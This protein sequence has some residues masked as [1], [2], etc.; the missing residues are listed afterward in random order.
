MSAAGAPGFYQKAGTIGGASHLLFRARFDKYDGPDQWGN[1]GNFGIGMDLNGDGALDLILMMS[2]SSGNV[3]NRSRTL[4]WGDPGTGANTGPSTTSWAFPTQTATALVV[5]T[6]YDAVQATDSTVNGTSDL[7]LSF[8]V[9]FANLQAAV[10]AYTP[11]TTFTMTY[12]T[13]ITYIAFTS[14]QANSLNQDL[15]GT[16]GNTNSSLTWAQLG[17]ITGPADAYGVVP[18]PA[19][20]VQMAALFAAGTLVAW[21]R[22]RC[23][24]G[25]VGR[26]GP[27]A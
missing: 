21:R 19:T 24:S 9:S 12:D 25:V 10:R 13:R 7:L 5:N 17:A 22:R 27:A 26:T 20:Y 2:E 15:F 3:N 23:L 8:A 18:E 1:G 14:T 6:T 16:T 4:T 11:F